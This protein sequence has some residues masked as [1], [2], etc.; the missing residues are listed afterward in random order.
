MNEKL[1]RGRSGNKDS[2]HEDLDNCSFFPNPDEAQYLEVSDTVPVCA[3]GHPV[4]NFQPCEFSLPLSFINETEKVSEKRYDRLRSSICV[5]DP[6]VLTAEIR[7]RRSRSYRFLCSE[8]KKKKIIL[9]LLNLSKPAL[10]SQKIF[11]YVC[12]SMLSVWKTLFHTIYKRK[13]LPPITDANLLESATSLAEKIR[14]KKL[15]C[16]DVIQSYITRIRKVNPILNAVVDDNFE[17]ALKEAKK[18]DELI[19]SGVKTEKELEKEMPFLG[20]PFTIKDSIAVKGLHQTIGM[21]S[22]RDVIADKDAEAVVAIKKAGAINIAN[23]NVPELT[24][25]SETNNHLH[26]TTNNPHDT[27]RSCGGSSG[28]EGSLIGAAASVIGI[29]SDVGGSI[30]IPSFCNGI[31]GHKPT[32]GI[33]SNEGQLPDSA[34]KL[35]N[36]NTTGPLCRYASDLLPM[37]KVLAGPNL[38]KL[39]LDT[40][41]DV[42]TLRY[43]YM[44]NDGGG[45]L[46]SKV[47]NDIKSCF[48]KIN[49]HLT[50]H[51]GIRTKKV[52]IENL[53]H[54]LGIWGV[55]MVGSG[56]SSLREAMAD[57]QGKVY[58]LLEFL[59]WLVY[60]SDHTLAAISM[61][62]L[63]ETIVPTPNSKNYDFYV[64]KTKE[65]IKEFNDLLGADGVFIYPVSPVVAPFHHQ[66][67]LMIPN[68]GHTAVFNILGLPSTC[69]TFGLNKNGVPYGIQVVAN[70]YND[71]LCLAVARE[72]EDA[73]GGWVSPSNIMLPSK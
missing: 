19:L 71:H 44:E 72:I 2:S 69:C 73:F 67:H 43:F 22:R 42:K 48:D 16:V 23:S 9:T 64:N 13:S 41:V 57:G 34:G 65:L 63:S 70:K 40:Q 7:L 17:E 39:K 25:W 66:T 38:D 61:A 20:V 1:K 33:V 52:N 11:Q 58:P 4:P 5:C 56:V 6:I 49:N 30:R 59:K 15:K 18:V 32:P 14:T 68:L 62:L 24:M 50:G 10:L 35:K 27:R 37:F 31:F 28:G 3:F 55:H 26:G 53:K 8:L 51:Y 21:V 36:Y 47:S 29:G 12:I 60:M 45:P 54:S 46:V